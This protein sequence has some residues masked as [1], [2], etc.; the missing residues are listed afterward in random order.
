[1]KTYRISHITD[2]LDIPPE[3]WDECMRDIRGCMV[4]LHL[5]RA[6]ASCAENAPELAAPSDMC[7][8]IEFTPDGKGDITPMCGDMPLMTLR[9]TRDGQANALLDANHLPER[10]NE[11]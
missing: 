5:L 11:R 4:S 2:L 1:M 6:A 3:H 9:V 10:Q 8:F 7:P